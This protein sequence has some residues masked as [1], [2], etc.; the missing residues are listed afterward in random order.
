MVDPDLILRKLADLDQYLVQVSEY[1]G[2]TVEEYRRDWKI[3]RIVERTLQM[4]IEVCVDVASHIIAD[5]GLRVPATYAEAFEILGEAGLLDAA[6]TAQMVRMAGF[7]NV[8]VHEYARVDA[9]IVVGILAGRLGDLA[10]FRATAL[11][12][13]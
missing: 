4:A 12:W 1:R 13:Q 3:Q 5:R 8:L 9:E 6:L 7:R 10:R 11:A 2:I